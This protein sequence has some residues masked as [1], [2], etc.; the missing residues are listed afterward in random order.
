MKYKSFIIIFALAFSLGVFKCSLAQTLDTQATDTQATAQNTTTKDQT[1]NK[2]A[3]GNPANNQVVSRDAIGL[4]VVPNPEHLS[5]LAW[6]YKNIKVKGAP[7]SMLVDGYE[8]VRDG[9][10]V[11]VNAAKIVSGISRCSGTNKICTSDSQCGNIIDPGITNLPSRFISTAWA[12]G[13]CSVSDIPELYTNIY[14]ISYNQ[15]PEASTTDI[16]GQLLQYWKFNIDIK[17]CSK[18][19]TQICSE[20]GDCP[21]TPSDSETCGPA[22]FCSQTTNKTCIIDADCAQGEYCNSKKSTIIRD[23]KRLV[24]LGEVK[25]KLEDYNDIVHSYPKL[26]SGTYLTNRTISTW[27]SWSATFSSTIGSAMPTDSINKLGKCKTDDNENVR[28]EAS[29]CWDEANKEFAG[30]ANPLTLPANSRAYYYQYK[31]ADNSF[32]FCT[33]AESGYILAKAPFSPLCQTG[34]SCNINCS[35]KQCGD[36]GCG[37]TCGTCTSGQT[38]QSGHCRNNSNL[39]D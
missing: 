19:V 9:R 8:A 31:P 30:G 29:T 5:P 35:N 28:F 21:R 34:R 20:N 22:G 10:T 25:I 1:V 4:R 11:Y 36:N 17:N 12:A 32:S 13:T 33:I 2:D 39:Q 24:D 23:T 14:I 18:T 16:F 38:C 3:P 37:G 26:D 15:N 6:Y 27:P 7:Q